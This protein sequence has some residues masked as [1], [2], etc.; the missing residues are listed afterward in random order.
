MKFLK[1][2]HEYSGTVKY[3]PLKS[4]FTVQEHSACGS[5]QFGSTIP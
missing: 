2:S 1:N 5:V 4:M 3:S